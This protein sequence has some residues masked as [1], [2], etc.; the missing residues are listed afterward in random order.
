MAVRH[1]KSGTRSWGSER[2]ETVRSPICRGRKGKVEESGPLS[3]EREPGGLE[4]KPQLG[5]ATPKFGSLAKEAQGWG[6]RLK[7][8]R[9]WRLNPGWEKAIS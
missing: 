8:L 6:L 3:T 1:F 5:L 9:D 4:R 2:R 7:G